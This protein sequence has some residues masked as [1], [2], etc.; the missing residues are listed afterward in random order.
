MKKLLVPLAAA[1]AVPA[2]AGAGT[3]AP[4]PNTRIELAAAACQSALPVFDGVIRKRPMAVQ[5]EGTSSSF[6][7]CGLEGRFY[8]VPSSSM[9]GVLVTNNTAQAAT[10]NCT[11]VDGGDGLMFPVYM[12]KSVNLGPNAATV[13]VSWQPGD[14]GGANFIYPAISCQLPPGIGIK[15]IFQ[16]FIAS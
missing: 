2:A 3:V 5:N 15:A 13:T 1:L 14:N 12:P 10:L 8:A 7:T 4:D 6:I 11:L 16:Q 9:V